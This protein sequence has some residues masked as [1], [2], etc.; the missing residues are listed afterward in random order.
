MQED[1]RESA[2]LVLVTEARRHL[3]QQLAAA[4]EVDTKAL[5]LL[6]VNATV[7]TIAAAATAAFVSSPVDVAAWVRSLFAVGIFSLLV[8][9][10]LAGVAYVRADFN[11][12]LVGFEDEIVPSMSV[13]D[14][15]EKTLRVYA[16]MLSANKAR[17]ERKSAI[18]EW[19]LWAVFL[20]VLV[21]GLSALAL[22][23]STP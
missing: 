15:C 18:W 9:T 13:S 7:F 16:G 8:S 14:I 5:E 6:K 23:A 20:G 12:G 11:V 4:R 22:I 10:L 2:L 1:P 19:S 3:D 17:I 21:L